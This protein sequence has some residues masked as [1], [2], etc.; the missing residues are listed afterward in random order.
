MKATDALACTYGPLAD[1]GHGC[2]VPL[3]GGRDDAG[4]GG[5]QARPGGATSVPPTGVAGRAAAA[6]LPLPVSDGG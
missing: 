2:N 6:G 1:Q 3:R 5:R 4:G